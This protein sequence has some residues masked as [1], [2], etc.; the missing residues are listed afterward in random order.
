MMQNSETASDI[1]PYDPISII[2]GKEH[3]GRVRG[4]SHRACF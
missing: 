4:L 3:A 2:F 1:S